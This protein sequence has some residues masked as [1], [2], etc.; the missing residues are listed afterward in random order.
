MGALVATFT[1]LLGNCWSG[2]RVTSCLLKT[3]L[4]Y[5]F[6]ACVGSVITHFQP[7]RRSIA[8]A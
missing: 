1:P 7:A 8:L 3:A 2:E 6:I 4:E 5:I